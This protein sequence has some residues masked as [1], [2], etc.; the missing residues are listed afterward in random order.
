VNNQRETFFAAR[1]REKS[2]HLVDL[3]LGHDAEEH[4]FRLQRIP[5]L[6][7]DSARRVVDTHIVQPVVGLRALEDRP[8]PVSVPDRV[9]G[10][11]EDY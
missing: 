10:E 11:V 5:L 1:S 7:S 6:N 8:Y 3:R 4:A 2:V 9:S